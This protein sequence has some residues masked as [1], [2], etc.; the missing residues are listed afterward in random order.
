MATKG[1]PIYIYIYRERERERTMQQNKACM[2]Q[3]NR[4]KKKLS[5]STVQNR[6]RFLRGELLRMLDVRQKSKAFIKVSPAK[7]RA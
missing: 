7:T 3:E 6:N 2:T 1:R 4:K 5:Y